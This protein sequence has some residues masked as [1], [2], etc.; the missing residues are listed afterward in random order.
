MILANE[1]TIREVMAFPKT[2]Q[3]I[4]VMTDA[5]SLVDEKQLHDLHITFRT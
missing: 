2:Q 4:D 1:T 5:P 3:A